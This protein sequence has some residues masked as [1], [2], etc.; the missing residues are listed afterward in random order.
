[1]RRFIDIRQ[2]TALVTREM[3]SAYV[4]IEDGGEHLV[5]FARQKTGYGEKLFFICPR[6]GKRREK[7]YISGKHL[8][9]RECCPKPIYKDIKNVSVGSCKYL[10]HRMRSLAKKERI[11]IKRF[12]FYYLDYEKP[13]YRHT[14]SW[15]MAITKLQALQNMRVQALENKRY[16][17]EVIDSIFEEKNLFLYIL[18]LYDIDKYVIDWEEG[19]RKW[20]IK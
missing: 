4:R 18:D 6:C 7:L 8:L 9:C 2:C 1:M 19:Y 13:K 10:T 12:P 20:P 17:L 5:N 14:D 3:N 16:S 11:T 15:H